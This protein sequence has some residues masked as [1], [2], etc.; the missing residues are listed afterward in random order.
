MLSLVSEVLKERQNKNIAIDRKKNILSAVGVNIAEFS[1]LD[2]D[3]Y[4]ID[5]IDTLIITPEGSLIN[6]ISIERVIQIPDIKKKSA[7]I[8]IIT[9]KSLEYRSQNLVNSL[10]KNK[11]VFCLLTYRR[12]PTGRG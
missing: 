5:N 12:Q 6:N 7:S 4:F 10:K 1:I 3:Q 11:N 8:V 9:H 2:I